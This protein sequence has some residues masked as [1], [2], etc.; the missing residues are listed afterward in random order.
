MNY[1]SGTWTLKITRKS[2]SIDATQNGSPPHTNVKKIRKYRETKDVT[3]ENDDTQDLRSTEDESGDG[4]SSAAHND[5]DSNISFEHD[6]NDE[7]ETTESEEEDWIDHK[8]KH[9]RSQ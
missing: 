6:T 9:R 2:D 8:K 7:V 3:K 4:Q 1:A 5:Q